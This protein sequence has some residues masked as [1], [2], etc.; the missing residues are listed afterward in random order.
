MTDD[1]WDAL[2]T[3][4][5]ARDRAYGLS[6]S[7]PAPR[8]RTLQG[9][10]IARSEGFWAKSSPLREACGGVGSALIAVSALLL[11]R[12]LRRALR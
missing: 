11:A 5:S 7:A 3:G 12:L 8:A 10:H 4:R 2:V 9:A 1:E 6:T